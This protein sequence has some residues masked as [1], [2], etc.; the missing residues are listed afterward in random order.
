MKPTKTSGMCEAPPLPS[1]AAAK[2][3]QHADGHAG[4]AEHLHADAAEA[5][6]RPQADG[7]ADE[8][9]H[10]DGAAALARRRSRAATGLNEMPERWMAL[11][12]VGVNRPTP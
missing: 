5:R 2:Q 1:D 8:Q 11:R 4:E 12:M 3:D 7:K 10:V 9:E 6:H